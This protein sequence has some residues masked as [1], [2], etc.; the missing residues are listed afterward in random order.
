MTPLRYIDAHRQ[1]F[2]DDL[3]TFLR[4]PSISTSPEN[5][6]DVHQ[7][8]KWLADKF[9][10]L[11]FTNIKLNET[12]GHPI[13][14]GEWMNAGASAPTILLYG[15]Y[16]VQPVDPL[17]LWLKGP[18][19][20]W[21][22]GDRIYARGS[23]DDKGQVWIHV[24]GLEAQLKTNGKLPVNVKLLIEGEEEIGS[25]NL[26][27]FVASHK[28]ELK[29]DIVVISDTGM[30]A[31]DLPTLAYG[32]RGLA[33]FQIDL[34][35]P[36]RDLHSGQYG[37]AVANP[38]F[39]LARIIAQ[40]KTPQGVVTIPGFYDAVRAPTS[41]ERKEWATLPHSDTEY[42]AELD[43]DAIPGEQS[44]STLER[45]WVRPTLEVNGLL[46]G[47]TGEG[48]KTVLPAKAMAKISCRLVPDQDFKDI[49]EKF[50]AFVTSLCPPGCKMKVTKHHG[51][52]PVITERENSFVK[53]AERALKDAFG[54][55]PVYT[56]IGGSIPITAAFKETLGLD[57]V[58][59]GFS[60]PNEN[61]HSPNEWLSLKNFER[62]VVTSALFW[63]EAAKQ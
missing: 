51:G 2:L 10:S 37:G 35:G 46:S 14:T 15:H 13:L 31:D 56:R 52:Q 36:N 1:L 54:K 58:L 16:D 25:P 59:L 3:F 49:E 32:L 62:G 44:F 43:V 18:F 30:F 48:A 27:T 28:D 24:C 53:A 9:T 34:E 33:Y 26:V 63:E 42:M 17:E 40:L 41:E 61:A 21:I 23:A 29:A 60:Q 6:V 55:D 11:G 39:E 22:D 7:C 8:G 50:V 12:P 5:R 20:P 47:F 19:E 45:L 4:F 38:A 57:T